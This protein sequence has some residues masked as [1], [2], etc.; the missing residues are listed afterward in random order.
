M[1]LWRELKLP[2]TPSIHLL[3]DHNVSQMITLDGGI[4]DK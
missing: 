4:A 1:V 3:E 2:V